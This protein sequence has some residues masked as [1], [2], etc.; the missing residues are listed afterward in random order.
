MLSALLQQRKKEVAGVARESVSSRVSKV[1]LAPQPPRSRCP[2]MNACSVCRYQGLKSS[3]YEA[4][5]K[6]IKNKTY[7]GGGDKS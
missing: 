2:R 5:R 3:L 1:T 4:D 7:W 6:K